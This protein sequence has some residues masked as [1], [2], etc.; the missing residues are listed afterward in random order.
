MRIG[1]HEDSDTVGRV[2]TAVTF[3]MIGLGAGA[4]VALLLAPTSGKRMRRELRKRYETAR[5]TLETW[6]DDARE[7]A[8]EAVE[9]GSG[10]A[11][12][13]RDRVTP[14]AKAVRRP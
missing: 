14:L 1:N 6:K 2:G 7:M 10:I 13:I 5:D 8:E 11:E 12:G 3:L 4:L 9:R